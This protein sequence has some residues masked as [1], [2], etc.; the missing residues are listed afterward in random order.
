MK[1]VLREWSQL[2]LII[3]ENSGVAEAECDHVWIEVWIYLNSA[4]LNRKVSPN[5]CCTWSSTSDLHQRSYQGH[6][7]QSDLVKVNTDCC[8]IRKR[9][10]TTNNPFPNT[11]NKLLLLGSFGKKKTN[12]TQTNKQTKNPVFAFL[13]YLVNCLWSLF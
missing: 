2:S 4:T 11:I 5:C 12:N 3:Q 13:Y 8:G 7:D 10:I 1:L 9:Q 6:G